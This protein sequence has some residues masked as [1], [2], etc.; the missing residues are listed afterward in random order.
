MRHILRVGIYICCAALVSSSGAYQCPGKVCDFSELQYQD[1]ANY[2]EITVTE[3]MTPTIPTEDP[4]WILGPQ[5]SRQCNHGSGSL[6]LSKSWTDQDNVNVSATGGQASSIGAS[7][8]AS[9]QSLLAA[10]VNGSVTNSTQTSWAWSGTGTD[11]W[12]L[13]D[14]QNYLDCQTAWITAYTTRYYGT[15]TQGV[16]IL[17]NVDDDRMCFSGRCNE[18]EAQGSGQHLD[19]N[20][21]YDAGSNDCTGTYPCGGT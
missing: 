8:Q 10:N 12:T 4:D 7:L 16:Y 15:F 3:P 21:Y 6:V 1:C 5:V 17:G 18:T 19:L 20:V 13:G 11:S 9:V 14:T 2:T